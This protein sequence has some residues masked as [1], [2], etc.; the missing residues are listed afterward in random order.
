MSHGA[1]WLYF[2]LRRRCYPN[3]EDNGRVFLSQ[4]EAAQ[5][6][7][8]HR[9]HIARWFREL[10][11]YDFII[12]T[13]PGRLGLNGKG[14]AP[15]WLLPELPYKDA[16]PTQNY[17]AWNGVPFTDQKTKSRPKRNG[18]ARPTKVGHTGKT[19]P[20]PTKVGHP[21]QQK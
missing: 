20:Q 18:R 8:S 12:M 17:L 6:L 1:K 7:N 10:Q 14:R 13:T 15:R 19:E 21:G 5:I 11:H 16:A 4:R 3:V 2:L 9:N